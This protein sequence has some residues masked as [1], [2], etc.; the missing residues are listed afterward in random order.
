Q[1]FYQASQEAIG[2]LL[3]HI[4]A[5]NPYLRSTAAVLHSL[6]AIIQFWLQV[7]STRI[8]C[9]PEGAWQLDI[10]LPTANE[11]DI[12]FFSAMLAS[13]LDYLNQAHAAVLLLQSPLDQARVGK[14]FGTHLGWMEFEKNTIRYQIFLQSGTES[15][16]SLGAILPPAR[17][18]SLNQH[19][20][21]QRHLFVRQV[22]ARSARIFQDKRELTT[23]VEFLNFANEELEKK[24]QE[25]NK[26]LQMARSIQNGLFPQTVPDWKGLH[27]WCF[28]EE[29][30]GVSGD[31]FDT[32]HLNSN[33]MAFLIADVCGHGVPAAL[34]SALAKISF[35]NHSNQGPQRVLSNVNQDLIR[36]VKMEGYLTAIILRF[37]S[38]LQF[39]Y[40]VAG[41]PAPL[42]YRAR[43]H[44][45]EELEGQ[46]CLLGM[47][48]DAD[49]NLKEYESALETGDKLFL[50]TDGLTELS[51][52]AD[53]LLGTARL[54]EYILEARGLNCAGAGQLVLDKC[55]EFALGQKHTD[56]ITMV[57]IEASPHIDQYNEYMQSARAAFRF[58]D[59][60]ASLANLQAALDLFPEKPQTLYSL[61]K[62][63][64]AENRV[65]EADGYCDH[66]LQLNP[67]HIG[68]LVC[69]SIIARQRGL[70]ELAEQYL[71]EAELI[72]PRHALV[73]YHWS[74]VYAA[75]GKANEAHDALTQ[76]GQLVHSTEKQ[77]R[78]RQHLK[79]LLPSSVMLD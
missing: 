56:D 61:T 41:M 40:S 3:L 31:F 11:C 75:Q 77:A 53:E 16:V 68:G 59:R 7:D 21:N 44:T 18:I 52:T 13:L 49:Q 54:H 69:K 2:E 29:L 9:D 30:V 10:D 32:F 33:E 67:A 1:L 22:L 8:A 36:H 27:F 72:H 73:L 45:V 24:I 37:D 58:H 43:T 23:A 79:R 62:L 70:Y 42:V 55:R 63:L 26:E 74:L 28:S 25:S 65:A 5:H 19:K 14:L 78:L 76:F 35:S 17:Q 48:P 38:T 57:V 6:P 34:I 71:K 39:R 66:L 4:L 50:F 60:Q 15:E 51:N 47:F 20:E 64:L 46:G 12:I